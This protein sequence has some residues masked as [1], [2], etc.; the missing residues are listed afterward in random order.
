MVAIIPLLIG[1]T[2]ALGLVPLGLGL[3]VLGTTAP[4]PSGR[5]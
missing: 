1:V 2:A 4:P 5:R 3:F